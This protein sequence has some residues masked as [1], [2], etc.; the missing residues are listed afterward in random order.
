MLGGRTGVWEKR[1]APGGRFRITGKDASS[2]GRLGGFATPHGEFSTPTFMPVGTQGTVK[3]M[4]PEELKTLGT[5]ILLCNAYH[6]HL[7]PG[8]D[9]IR[10]LGGLHG[11]MHWEGPIL[12][13][14]GGFQVFSLSSLRRISEEG[15]TFRSHLDGSERFIDPEGAVRIQDTLGTDVAMCLDECIPYPAPRSYAEESS[16]RTLRWAARC[17]QSVDRSSRVALF[18]IVQGG[19]FGDIRRQSAEDLVEIGFDGYALGGLS[20][21]ESLQERVEMVGRAMEVLPHDAPRYL[22]GVGSPED[23]VT[24]MP[25]GVDLFDCVLPT[26]CARNG[27]LFTREGRLDIRHAE[28]ARSQLPIDGGCGCYTCRNYSRAYLRHLYQA[29]E[30]LA[31]RLHTLHNLHYYMEL[32]RDIRRAIQEGRGSQF[33]RAFFQDRLPAN[34]QGLPQGKEGKEEGA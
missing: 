18:G 21:G 27:M 19:M 31:A 32:V 17:R 28:H 24:F 7:R 2:N 15:V 12:T 23:L 4:T 16:A 30:I 10:G 1:E 26:R 22:M 25:M 14:S 33:R 8:E 5:D 9:V 11:F 13:D 34:P 20:V 29:R 6:L 3:G